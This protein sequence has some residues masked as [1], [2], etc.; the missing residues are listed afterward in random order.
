[1]LV[2]AGMDAEHYVEKLEMYV[3]E[4]K[5]AWL[6]EKNDPDKAALLK[7]IYR[8]EREKLDSFQRPQMAGA[9]DLSGAARFDLHGMRQQVVRLAGGAVQGPA[10]RPASLAMQG[11][12]LLYVDPIRAA[13]LAG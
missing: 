1:M 8:E 3:K 9:E 2:A 12:L 10:T 6:A 11:C 13:P 4:A 5:E 7:S